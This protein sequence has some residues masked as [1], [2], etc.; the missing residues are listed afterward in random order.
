M[1][2]HPD[3]CDCGREHGEALVFGLTRKWGRRRRRN[4]VLTLL[5]VAAFLAIA[6]LIT[7]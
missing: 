3:D 6:V 1:K 7:R 2:V 5:A 4:A